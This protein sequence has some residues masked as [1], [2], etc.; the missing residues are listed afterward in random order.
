MDLA[1][2]ITTFGIIAL[3]ELGDKTQLA[4]MTLSAK[5]RAVSVFAGAMLAMALVDGLSIL[6]GSAL[7]DFFSAQ[8][9]GLVGAA[10][11]IG[12]GIRNLISKEDEEVKVRS[13]KSAVLTSF[14]MVAMMELGDKTQ[15]SV[16]ALAAQY[17][18]PVLVFLGMM[19]AFALLMGMGVIVG[20]KLVKFV[21]KRY[22]KIF[23]GALFI[24]FGLVFLMG[25]LGTSF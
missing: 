24:I 6:V 13:G 15:F 23:T 5:Y 16:I 11:F 2:L 3:A 17:N 1:P 8:I 19:L 9:M 21:P 20:Y 22:L 25:A 7:A 12:F 10:I 18:A 4:A 14:S